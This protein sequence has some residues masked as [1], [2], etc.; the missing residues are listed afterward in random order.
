MNS[1]DYKIFRTGLSHHI[2]NRGNNK[3]PIFLDAQDY[4]VFLNRLK[5][6]LGIEQ[7]ESLHTSGKRVQVRIKPLPAGA[8]SIFCYCLMPNHFHFFIR[9]NGLIG[10]DKLITK[11]CT[12]YAKYFNLKYGRVGNLF[13]DAFKAKL[14]ENDS[15]A[16]YLSAYIHNNPGEPL[17][18]EYS[19]L[20]DYVDGW[21]NEICDKSLILGMFNNSLEEYKKFVLNF[22]DSDVV[23][24]EPV[25]FKE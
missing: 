6:A 8:F 16:K 18:Y 3:E 1:R 4:Y 19:S 2:Y 5:L 15:C 25:L 11:V 7:R 14:V 10:I 13:Q 9:Q 12:S 17:L 22:S 20:R 21:K 24:L 23:N